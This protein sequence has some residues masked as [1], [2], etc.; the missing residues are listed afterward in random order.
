[1]PSSDQQT[2]TWK[3]ETKR[4]ARDDNREPAGRVVRE[5]RH[6]NRGKYKGKGEKEMMMTYPTLEDIERMQQE[7]LER[8]KELL[9]KAT[10]EKEKWLLEKRIWMI[11]NS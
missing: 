4:K 6:R 11:Q 9:E 1:M 5:H 7:R 10:D 3:K 8:A 2:R